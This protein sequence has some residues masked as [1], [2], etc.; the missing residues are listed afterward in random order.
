MLIHFFN[1]NNNSKSV[2]LS[3]QENTINTDKTMDET[4][5]ENLNKRGQSGGGKTTKINAS[6]KSIYKLL[7]PPLVTQKLFDDLSICIVFQ[8]LL[9]LANEHVS[10]LSLFFYFVFI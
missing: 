5:A 3:K 8:M 9:F 7:R 2:L 10:V 1:D 4:D 6:L